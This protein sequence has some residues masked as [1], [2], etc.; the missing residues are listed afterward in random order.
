MAD[1][2]DRPDDRRAHSDPV[3][4]ARSSLARAAAIGALVT[5][6]AALLLILA[7]RT[8]DVPPPGVA[9]GYTSTFVPPSTSFEV[10]LLHGDAQA[11]ATLALDPTLSHP[12]RFLE[13]RDQ[14]SYF[15]RRPIVP[16]AVWAL[17]AGQ[18]DALPFAVVVVGSVSLGLLAA[19]CAWLIQTRGRGQDDR[20][21][22][23]IA[24]T[25][26]FL[27]QVRNLGV[28]GLALALAIAGL[29]LWI[30]AE[31][32]RGVAAVLFALATLTRETMILVPVVVGLEA[33]SRH[34][35]GRRDVAWLALSPVL[36]GLWAVVVHI[37]FGGFGGGNNLSGP[38]RGLTASVPGWVTADWLVLA[39]ALVISVLALARDHRSVLAWLIGAYWV[40]A[41]FL[42]A[43]VWFN[44][45]QF[46][47]ILFPVFVFSLV[48]L[49]PERGR[50]DV[51]A[52]VAR[53]E[54]A[55]G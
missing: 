46:S 7:V 3:A 17:S 33:W 14:A 32:R 30:R 15:A 35:L 51:R 13:S 25:P 2:V 37:R 22:V 19:A 20:L 21:A 39:F 12:E 1:R 26:A 52:S 11:Y 16:A 31:P 10:L 4:G 48:I 23:L 43:P 54:G 28:E 41:V 49:L 36:Y 9:T 44:W 53:S 40:L 50:A 47:R 34:R 55:R 38:F 42:G 18:R 45:E 8:T 27:L 24:F 29:V 6:L 5:A